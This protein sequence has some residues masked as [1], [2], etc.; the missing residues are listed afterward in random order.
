MKLITEFYDL[1]SNASKT[2]TQRQARARRLLGGVPNNRTITFFTK[3]AWVHEM[4]LLDA[5]VTDAD[6]DEEEVP[7]SQFQT[8]LEEHFMAPSSWAALRSRPFS[9]FGST[10]SHITPSHITANLASLHV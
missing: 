2:T 6:N 8:F 1:Y 4:E 3:D 5:G 7:K 9:V 10:F